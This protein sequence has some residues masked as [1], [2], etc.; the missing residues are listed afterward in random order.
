[1][2]LLGSLG[3]K[4]SNGSKRN[5][6]HLAPYAC[7]VNLINRF[8]FF[9]LYFNV[10]LNGDS[11]IEELLTTGLSYKIYKLGGAAM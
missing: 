2:S 11:N 3:D 1:M 8:R 4:G 9:I 5:N 6:G 10:I 7:A